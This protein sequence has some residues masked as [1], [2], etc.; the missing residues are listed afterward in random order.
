MKGHNDGLA[1]RASFFNDGICD[2]FGQLAFP[3]GGTALQ[4]RNLD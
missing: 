3:F 2:P 4:H 1:P